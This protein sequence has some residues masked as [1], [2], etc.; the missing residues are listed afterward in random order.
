VN[1]PEEQKLK[2]EAQANIDRLKT[3]AYPGR[4][5]VLGQ[6]RQG[7]LVQI[8]WIMGRSENSR[9]RV[10]K[11]AGD[12]V[13]TQAA[14]PSKLQDPRLVIYYPVR[15]R[16]LVHIVSNGDQTDTIRQFLDQGSGLSSG[17]NFQT[18]LETRNYEPDPPNF[19]PRISGVMDLA[20]KSCAYR[21]SIVK[22]NRQIEGLSQRNFFY[23][24]QA[25]RGFGH[26]ITTY[27]GDGNPLPTFAGEPVV[28]PIQDTIEAALAYWWDILNPENRISLLV[29]FID[30]VSARSEIRIQNKYQQV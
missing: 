13:A 5:I 28:V 14:D 30:P 1:P 7:S 22:A 4:G 12:D 16:G 29:K 3:N 10:F 6:N 11:I 23:Y 19:T 20:E 18:A 2:I 26:C 21:L 15:V 9:N 25:L 8:Y 17:L 24:Q 27:Q